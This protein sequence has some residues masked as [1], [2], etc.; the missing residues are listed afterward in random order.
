MPKTMIAT[1]KEQHFAK[2]ISSTGVAVAGAIALGLHYSSHE[3]FWRGRRDSLAMQARDPTM[4]ME[5]FPLHG[6]LWRDCVAKPT[7]WF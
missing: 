7:L 5:R 2:F 6:W 1:N 3:W 4:P